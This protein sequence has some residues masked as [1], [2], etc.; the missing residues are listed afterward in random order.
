MRRGKP[1]YLNEERYAALTNM[2]IS[3]LF[4][5]F[6]CF[7][8][9]NKGFHFLMFIILYSLNR[10]LLMALIAVQR[11]SVKLPLIPYSR[12][13]LVSCLRWWVRALLSLCTFHI[14]DHKVQTFQYLVWLKRS[15]TVFMSQPI[16]FVLFFS[17]RCQIWLILLFSCF[18]FC[19]QTVKWKNPW[20]VESN[21]LTD[22]SLIEH[23]E[24]LD[25]V[26]VS[27]ETT[28]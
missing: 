25:G 23:I 28:L 24:T 26:P 13:S 4:F 2:V 5:F 21:A 9:E 3:K 6:F 12:F 7:V 1:L 16:S 19:C 18:I 8:H 15:R 20:H 11:F 27:N 17:G 22:K 10:L 14:N